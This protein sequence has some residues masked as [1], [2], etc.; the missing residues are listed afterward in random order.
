MPTTCPKCGAQR[1][2]GETCRERFDLFLAKEFENPGTYGAVHH[3]TVASYMLQHNGYSREAWPKVRE[4]LRQFIEDGLTPA[5]ARRQN[6]QQVDSGKRTWKV[7]GGE[8]LPQ[9]DAITW[10]RT[11]ADVRLETVEQYHANITAW[12]RSVLADTEELVQSLTHS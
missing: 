4:M 12:A 7:T 5:E 1:P 6:R 10:S 2:T 11:V 9:V 8:K 3:L